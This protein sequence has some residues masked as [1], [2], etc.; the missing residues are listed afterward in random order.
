VLPYSVSRRLI[1][2][3]DLGVV[4]SARDYYNS[5]RKELPNKSKLKTIV[6]LLRM[7]EDQQFVYRTRFKVEVDKQE[8]PIS[9]KLEQ[10]FFAHREQLNAATR[11]IADWVIEIDGTFNINEDRLPLLVYVGILSINETFPVAFSYCHSES[12]EAIGFMWESLKAKCFIPEIAP[13]RVIIGD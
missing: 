1:D 9:R 6:V 7:L 3:E 10:L 4:L 12:A 11:F 2:A 8:V 5:V 13:P